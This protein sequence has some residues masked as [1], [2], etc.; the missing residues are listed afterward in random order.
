MGNRNLL[1]LGFGQYGTVAKETAE[2]MGCFDAISFLDDQNQ[3]AMGVLND[4]EK[5]AAEYSHA[6]V[7][8][9]NC[10]IRHKWLKRLKDAGFVLP[11]LIHPQATVMPSATIAGGSIIEAQAMVHSNTQLAE[12]SIISAG[13]VVNHNAVLG[14][15][16]HIDCNAVVPAGQTVPAQTKV[17]CGTVFQRKD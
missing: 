2:A 7:A 10:V 13:A 11:V 15:C 9:G 14:T 1:I 5:F 6:F 16:C 3:N 12:G 4:F 17:F 8:M